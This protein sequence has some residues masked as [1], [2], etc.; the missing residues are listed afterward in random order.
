MYGL[1]NDEI[2]CLLFYGLVFIDDA[3]WV[4]MMV[5]GCGEIVGSVGFVMV[6]MVVGCGVIVGSV[7]SVRER[8][9]VREGIIK[10]CKRMNILLNKCVKW[11]GKIKLRL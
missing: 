3:S 2:L 8:G 6:M 4:V 7:G 11:V 9:A 10:N 1:G 5:V